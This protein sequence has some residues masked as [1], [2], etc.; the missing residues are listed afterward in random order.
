MAQHAARKFATPPKVDD[1]DEKLHYE[2]FCQKILPNSLPIDELK[3]KILLKSSESECQL[4]L[5]ILSQVE[6]LNALLADKQPADLFNDRTCIVLYNSIKELQISQHFGGNGWKVVC[7]PTMVPMT[8]KIFV[9][10]AGVFHTRKCSLFLSWSLKQ[11]HPDTNFIPSSNILTDENVAQHSPLV[12]K[13]TPKDKLD[14]DWPIENDLENLDRSLSSNSSSIDSGK[15]ILP[16]IPMM[17]AKDISNINLERDEDCVDTTFQD[18]YLDISF[19]NPK[20]RLN[21]SRKEK[22][23]I[24]EGPSKRDSYASNHSTPLRSPILP[25]PKLSATFKKTQRP[26]KKLSNPGYIQKFLDKWFRSQI[27]NITAEIQNEIDQ[28]E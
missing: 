9:F 8:G 15:T 24:L 25:K 20:R 10:T 6:N 21:L 27:A 4:Q 16:P 1:F 18:S 12:K 26:V 22:I 13:P 28:M 5:K 3:A 14:V 19:V 17:D 7:F 11:V 23:D 2:Y